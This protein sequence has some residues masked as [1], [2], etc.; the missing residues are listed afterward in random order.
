MT[1]VGAVTIAMLSEVGAVNIAMLSEVGA[2]NIAMLSE[3]PYLLPAYMCC[4][5]IAVYCTGQLV[6]EGGTG[7][8]VRVVL[9]LM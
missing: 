2:V 7:A 3:V 1:Q 6:C 5:N 4:L 8:N 9:V